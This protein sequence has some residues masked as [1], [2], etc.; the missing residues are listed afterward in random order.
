MRSLDI[1]SVK[2]TVKLSA[3]DIPGKVMAMK[4]CDEVVC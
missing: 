1:L 2:K 3:R 4:I